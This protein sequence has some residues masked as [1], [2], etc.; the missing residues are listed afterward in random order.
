[1][2]GS[3]GDDISKSMKYLDICRQFADGKRKRYSE[4]ELLSG[5]RRVVTTGAVKTYIDSQTN[6]HLEEVL[7]FLRSFLKEKT[8]AELHNDLSQ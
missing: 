7:L 8:P 2:T 5:L 4:D 1:M 3:I 6:A